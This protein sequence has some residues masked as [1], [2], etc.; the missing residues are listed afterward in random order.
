MMRAGFA[1]LSLLL[2][3]GMARAQPAALLPIATP[4]GYGFVTPEGETAIAPRF[5]R[6]LAFSE[7]RAAARLKGLWGFIDREGRE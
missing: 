7:G 3:A 5:E 6:V 1:F 4:S 2:A